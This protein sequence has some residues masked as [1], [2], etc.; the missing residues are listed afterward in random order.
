MTS[1]N[2]HPPVYA[3]PVRAILLAILWA[4]DHARFRGATA[5]IREARSLGLVNARGQLTATGR[6]VA[7]YC[8][9]NGGYS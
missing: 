3:H 1:D 4:D 8:A 5:A 7:E 9:A 6:V 2:K